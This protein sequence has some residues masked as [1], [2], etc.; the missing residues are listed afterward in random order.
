MKKT[1][2]ILL[3]MILCFVVLAGCSSETKETAPE[4][5]TETEETKVTV[6][7]PL[8]E[9]LDIDNLDNCT[10]AVSFEKGDAYVDD[11][12]KM[13]M[14]LTVYAYEVYDMV[15]IAELEENDVIL[16]QGEEIEITKLERLDTGLVRING[17][18]EEGGFDL[19]SDDSTVYYEMGMNDA[20][21]YYEIG[22]ITLPV[23]TEFE[24]VDNS[25]LDVGEVIYYPGD[26]LI[27]DAGFL[28]HFVPHNTSVVIDNG[29]IVKMDRR[30]VP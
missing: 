4:A 21:A 10:V 3:A 6:I 11:N 8:P 28:Y 1:L 17:G 12:G 22:N 18:E 27:D 5:K 20:K 29:V 30:F 25:D 2:S 19:F 14:D 9:T 13:M 26:F 23:S 15:D 24:F 7:S 16:R